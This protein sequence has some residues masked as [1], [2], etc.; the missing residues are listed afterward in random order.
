MS[1]PRRDRARSSAAPA[2]KAKSPAR[3]RAPA[4]PAVHPDDLVDLPDF[5]RAAQAVMTPLAWDYVSGAA[6]DEVTLRWNRTAFDHLRL[7]PRC[8]VDVSQLDTSVRLLGQRLPFPLLLAP[9]AYQ[10]LS[11]P[12]GEIAVARGAAEA[13]ALFVVSSFSNTTLEEIAASTRGPLWFQLYVQPDRTFTRDL[14]QRAEAAGYRALVVTVDTPVLGPRYREL[15]RKFKL[16]A[17]LDRANLRGLASATGGHRPSEQSIYSATL[18]PALT[19]RD[20]E[21]LRSLTKLP[22]VLKGISHPDDAAAAVACGVDGVIVSNHGA[23]NLDTGPATIDVLPRV[24]DKIGGKIPVLVDG[25]IRR[26]TDIL[27]ALA[28]GANA[29]LIGRPYLYG[30]SVEGARGV[31]RVVNILRRE[32]ESAMALC[33]RTSVAQIDRSVLWP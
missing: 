17:G 27:K 5:E 15:R 4:K 1:A 3:Q 12:E 18:E 22:I 13:D 28:L 21:W 8:L 6:A 29:T 31:T 7:S 19:W 26:G 9:T 25:G 10:K 16:P 30:L 23:R 24:A 20:I 14:V 32:L 33:G 11:H 2:K